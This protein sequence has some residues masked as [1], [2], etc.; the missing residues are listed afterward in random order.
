MTPDEVRREFAYNAWANRRLLDATRPV[1]A[2]EFVR[3]RGGSFGSMRGT[4]V[5]IMAGEWKWLRFWNDEPYDRVFR[6]EQYP[7]VAAL[8]NVWTQLAL[9]LDAFAAALTPEQLAS[10]REARNTER[11]LADTIR[12]L[13]NHSAY[14]RGQVVT[15]LRQAGF[16]APKTDFLDF[17]EDGR[18]EPAGAIRPATA[19]D[20]D[21]I[22]SL[23][24]DSF[25]EFRPLYTPDGYRATTP[26][27]DEVQRRF[28]DGPVWVAEHDGGVAGT[29]SAIVRPDGVYIRSMAVSPSARGRG[30][31]RLLLH[32]VEQFA[33]SQERTRLYLST[34]PF[35]SRAI[36][37]YERAGFTRTSAPPYELFGTALFTMEK[38]IAR[39]LIRDRSA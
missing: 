31:G 27:R 38:S 25:V 28:T 17:S 36:R 3:D 23:L 30:V 26:D 4:L 33:S 29:V 14:H 18:L 22:A 6:Q 24:A 13:L 16:A 12:H 9:E 20:A 10:P 1:P 35:L 32:E 34:T 15:L 11:T 7:T 39:R 2:A 19:G 5:H 21:A 8:E 37:L